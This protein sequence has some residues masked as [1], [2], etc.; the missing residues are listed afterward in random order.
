M[1]AIGDLHVHPGRHRIMWQADFVDAWCR[2]CPLCL[3]TGGHRLAKHVHAEAID[4]RWLRQPVGRI[5]PCSFVRPQ[6]TGIPS[7]SKASITDSAVNTQRHRCILRRSVLLLRRSA[8][9]FPL[10]T[11]C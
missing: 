10:N 8:Q 11:R 7:L 6:L 5:L 4:T 9:K 1:V 2:C 3:E